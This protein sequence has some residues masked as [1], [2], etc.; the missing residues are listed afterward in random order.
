MRFILAAEDGGMPLVL[1]GPESP[2]RGAEL[3]NLTTVLR[4]VTRT[5]RGDRAVVLR[6]RLAKQ[7]SDVR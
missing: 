2:D 7:L 5:L 1:T 3:V 6:L 4:P